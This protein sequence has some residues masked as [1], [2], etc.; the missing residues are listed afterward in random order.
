M[1][2]RKLKAQLELDTSEARRKLRRDLESASSDSGG[3]AGGGASRLAQSLDKAAQSADKT[4]QS[5]GQ[6]NSSALRLTRG[7]AGIAVGMATSYAANYMPQGP[8][9]NAVEYVG[10]A[11]TGASAGATLGPIGAAIGGLAGVLKT[12][13][14]KNSA[15]EKAAND[16]VKSDSRYEEN[17][18]WQKQ[19]RDLSEIDPAAV[20]A[21][22]EEANKDQAAKVDERLAE[23]KKKAVQLFEQQNRLIIDINELLQAGETEQ[24]AEL[25]EQLAIVRARKEQ[26]E[27]LERSFEQR[28]KSLAREAEELALADSKSVTPRASM[29]ALDSLAKVGGLMATPALPDAPAPSGATSSSSVKS[30]A[31]AVAPIAADTT[32]FGSRAEGLMD[33]TAAALKTANERIEKIDSEQLRVLTEIKD[34]L[35]DNGG[36]SWQ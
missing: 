10:S 17:R 1:A 33:G 27:S 2:S 6:A 24:A 30:F 25:Q 35:K 11:V 32:E 22:K 26:M 9:R 28:K 18:L 23:V 34:A 13:M 4:A 3:G 20:G 16:F 31:F 29:S 12:Y 14:E 21:T 5:F 8:A 15:I 19:L 7:F 36:T